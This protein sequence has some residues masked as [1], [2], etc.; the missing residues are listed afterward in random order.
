[1]KRLE[2]KLLPTRRRN[3]QAGAPSVTCLIDVVTVPQTV[4]CYLKWLCHS[5]TVMSLYFT[6][7]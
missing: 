6:A 2:S 4:T 5:Y 7:L 3:A 1:M